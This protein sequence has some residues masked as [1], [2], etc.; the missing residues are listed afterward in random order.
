MD[1]SKACTATFNL[2]PDLVVSALTVPVAAVAG[3]TISGLRDDEEPGR[4]GGRL[5]DP[6]LPFDELDVG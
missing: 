2:L 5:D 3:S 6:L 1:A 4:A